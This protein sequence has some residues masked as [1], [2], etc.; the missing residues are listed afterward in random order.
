MASREAA[1]MFDALHKPRMGGV[2]EE[3]F[4]LNV[5]AWTKQRKAGGATGKHE[6]RME[7]KA[8]KQPKRKKRRRG[9][10]YTRRTMGQPARSENVT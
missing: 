9:R 5:R 7:T 10:K 1:Q 4:P 6:R 3:Q 8:K 2:N